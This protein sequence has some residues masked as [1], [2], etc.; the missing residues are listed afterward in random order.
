L[1]LLS[2]RLHASDVQRSPSAEVD[3]GSV[4]AHDEEARGMARVILVLA[5]LDNTSQAYRCAMESR[6][7]S[8]AMIAQSE[9]SGD[10]FAFMHNE[11]Q[12]TRS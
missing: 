6:C 12:T 9:P 3:A 2:G 4:G 1:F 8:S 5:S 10:C 11:T 7:T